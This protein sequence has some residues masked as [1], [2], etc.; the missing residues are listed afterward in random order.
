MKGDGVLS[1]AGRFLKPVT[2]MQVQAASTATSTKAIDEDNDDAWPEG[3]GV[4]VSKAAVLVV[5]CTAS[6]PPP[7]A[8]AT[9][10]SVAF[11][12]TTSL[13]KGG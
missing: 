7:T 1:Y 8:L 11:V 4:A 5:V 13:V 2:Q 10:C 12:V 6:E 9:N 3:R